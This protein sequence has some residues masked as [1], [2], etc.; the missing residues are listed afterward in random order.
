MNPAGQTT[1]ESFE[2]PQTWWK[3]PWLFG[4]LLI[5]VTLIVYQPVW[6]AGFIWDDDGF[7]VNNPLIKAADG[8][9]RF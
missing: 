1:E 2:C 9:Y 4:L 3:Q 6:H 5:G 7:L 8:L